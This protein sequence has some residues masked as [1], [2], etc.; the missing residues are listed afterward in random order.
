VK[1]LK[2]LPSN[3]AIDTGPLLLPVTREP[4]WDKIRKLLDMHEK[5]EIT[6]HIGLFNISE[7]ISAMY[8]LG[9]DVKT[10]LTYATLIYRR[11]NIV[12]DLQYTI[13]MG[14]L[15]LKARELKYSIPWGDISS[16]ATALRMK[17]PVLALDED[18]HFNK[19]LMVCNKL[20]MSIQVVRVK[21]L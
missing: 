1:E 13:L 20:N 18:K 19:I 14:R 4:G 8:G 7:L 17:I 9:Y 3:I 21:D 10:S 16:A 12:K 5:G 11:L 2:S 15:Q 6:L